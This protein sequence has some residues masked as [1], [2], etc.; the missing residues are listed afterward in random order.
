[1]NDKQDRE[2]ECLND[3][4]ND[5]CEGVF[6]FTVRDQDFFASKNY[7]EP[8]RCRSCVALKK[9]NRQKV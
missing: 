8:K 4:G 6:L 5:N 7:A 1:M 3:Q 2:I 9:R